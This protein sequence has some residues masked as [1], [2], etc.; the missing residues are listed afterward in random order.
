M[1]QLVRN[2]GNRARSNQYRWLCSTDIESSKFSQTNRVLGE[3]LR[4]ADDDG[5]WSREEMAKENFICWVN[6][7]YRQLEVTSSIALNYGGLTV[8]LASEGC[9]D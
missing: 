5:F 6:L 4:A 3:I 8:A 2:T 9:S 1:R 7:G